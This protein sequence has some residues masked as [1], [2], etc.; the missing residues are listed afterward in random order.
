MLRLKN[1]DMIGLVVECV[2]GNKIKI[3]SV[4]LK[5]H[6][7]KYDIILPYNRFKRDSAGKV[8]DTQ[9]GLWLGEVLKEV[10]D[11]VTV[12][13]FAENVYFK[14]TTLTHRIYDP[15][16]PDIPEALYLRG[17]LGGIVT[18]LEKEIFSE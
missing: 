15:E 18:W 10:H 11:P 2:N 16:V 3:E 17:S 5:F 12:K 1:A 7:S 8:I 13:H 4:G 6:N 14:N 9:S